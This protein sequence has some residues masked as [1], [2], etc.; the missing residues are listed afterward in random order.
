M[1]R[2]LVTTGPAWERIDDVRRITN[3]STGHIGTLLADALVRAGWDVVLLRGETS[4]APMPS[5]CAVDVQ[6]FAGVSDLRALL[7]NLTGT[8]AFNAIFHA[9]ALSDFIVSEVS[10]D[11]GRVLTERKIESRAG[12][13]VVRLSPAPKILP[14]LRNLVHDAFIVGWKFELNGD[15][16]NAIARAQRQLLEARTD[17]CVVNGPAYGDGFGILRAHQTN[18]IHVADRDALV[19][20][21]VERADSHPL[22]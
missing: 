16:S 15:R 11:D 6:T 20:A 21:L 13:I 17:L 22:G 10:D 4:T 9:A 12:D 14:E 8:N 2:A 18:I 7:G 5:E 19:T 1:K 3:F